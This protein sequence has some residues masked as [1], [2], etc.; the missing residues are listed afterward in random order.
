[1]VS[2]F[3]HRLDIVYDGGGGG[4][5]GTQLVVNSNNSLRPLGA[6]ANRVVIA[7][8]RDPLAREFGCTQR[9]RRTQHP[10]SFGY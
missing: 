6:S 4:G 2:P 10:D 8:S 1:M 9:R 7:D 3:A 5:I